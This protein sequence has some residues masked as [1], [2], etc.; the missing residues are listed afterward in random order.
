MTLPPTWDPTPLASFEHSAEYIAALYSEYT[1]SDN[2]TYIAETLLPLYGWRGEEDDAPPNATEVQTLVDAG[3]EGFA[4][5]L[6]DAT[7]L[8]RTGIRWSTDEHTGV[9]VTLYAYAAGEMGGQLRRDLAGHH[10]NTALPRYVERALGL[11]VDEVT[12]RLRALG[13]DW[14]P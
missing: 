2:A 8:L 1:G 4:M 13:D 6:A 12:R 3:P 5:A 11:D 9:D 10:E 7:N 14:I